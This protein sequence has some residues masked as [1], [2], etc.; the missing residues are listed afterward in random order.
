MTLIIRPATPG[1]APALAACIDRAYAAYAARLPDLPP[2]SDGI[3]ADIAQNLVWVAER[4]GTIVG[5][6]VLNA[7]ADPA[8]LANVAVDP[9]ARGTGLGRRL[10]DTGEAAC[11]NRGIAVLRLTTHAEMAENHALYRHL[12]WKETGRSGNKVRMEKHLAR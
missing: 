7:N 8:V 11:R 6:L 9:A 4:A 1:D 2:V 10:I 3:A 5:G 12:G